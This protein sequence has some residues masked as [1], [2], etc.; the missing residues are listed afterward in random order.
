MINVGQQESWDFTWQDWEQQQQIPVTLMEFETATSGKRVKRV[1]C[2]LIKQANKYPLDDL[3][4]FFP[5]F[6]DWYGGMFH[7]MQRSQI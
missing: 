7:C 1:I 6:N 4:Y 5:N 3:C 2:M